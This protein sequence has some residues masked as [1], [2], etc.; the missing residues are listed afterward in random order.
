M[1]ELGPILA[2][3]ASDASDYMTGETITMD[4]GWLAQ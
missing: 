2:Y 1:E 4:G 3:L